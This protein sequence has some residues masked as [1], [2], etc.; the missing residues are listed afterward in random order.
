MTPAWKPYSA[1][2]QTEPLRGL[3]PCA[4]CAP[5]HIHIA[6]LPFTTDGDYPLKQAHPDKR[7]QRRYAWT[8]LAGIALL[9]AAALYLSYEARG[10]SVEVLN[11]VVYATHEDNDLHL[12]LYLPSTPESATEAIAARPAV[13]LFHGGG[14]IAG[15][16]HQLAW[17]GHELAE[18]G[19]VAASVSYRMMPRYR[20]PE[21]VH[22]AKAAVRWMRQHAKDYHIDPDRIAASGHSA[23]GHLAMMLGTT[24]GHPF[25]EGEKNPGE[26]SAVQAVISVYGA[27][28]LTPYADPDSWIRIGG[29]AKQMIE[30]FVEELEEKEEDA[31]KSASPVTY[32]GPDSAPTLFIHGA[33][34]NV[35]PVEAAYKAYYLLRDAGTPARFVLLPDTG[36]SFDHFRPVLRTM[37]FNE[38]L[39]FLEEHLGK[40]GP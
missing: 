31:L 17:Y 1:P 20:F 9:S 10:E 38:M 28:D 27:V 7:R 22:D 18:Q 5:G 6:H 25:L 39:D 29:I 34:D 36:H 21:P 16:R 30:Y 13:L 32:I 3:R 12:T 35:V 2:A 4:D 19:Y 24:S 14:W 33:D 37:I 26:S 8:F 40:N 23:G 15:T 11:R